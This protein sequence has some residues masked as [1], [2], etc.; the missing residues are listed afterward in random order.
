MLDH[1][2]WGLAEIKFS[3]KIKFDVATK[4]NSTDGDDVIKE[5]PLPCQPDKTMAGLQGEQLFVV[6]SPFYSGPFSTKIES[7]SRRFILL[8]DGWIIQS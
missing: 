1:F 8:N 6:T 3:R 2:S 7:K 4:C 5:M